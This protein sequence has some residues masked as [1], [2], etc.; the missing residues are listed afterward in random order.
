MEI[1]KNYL[2]EN[3]CYKKNVNITPKGVIVHSTACPGVPAKNFLKSWNSFHPNNR[4]VC[5]HAFIDDTGIYQT[6]P[7]TMKGWHAGGAANSTYIGFE[8]C[9]PYN[10]D[11]KEYFNIVK[12]YAIDF[13]AYLCITYQIPVK[14]VIDHQEGY[15]LGLA[16]NHSDIAHW[17]VKYHNYN[18]NDFR[19][20]VLSTI[21]KQQ[22]ESEVER[23]TKDELRVFI[24]E[25]V[26]SMGIGQTPS[27][28][29][30]SLVADSVAAGI[31]DGSNPKRLAT[32]EEVMI[33]ALRASQ[34]NKGA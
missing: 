9:E 22:T 8:I 30:S 4:Q 34:N 25:T 2:Y 27:T 3:E 17:W 10:Y 23:M 31:T 14:S 15:K 26:K 6:L 20:D 28:W 24:E 32:R 1:V 7:F 13:V 29:A 12:S 33:M 5:V 16:S 11:A 18:M 19:Q 21:V